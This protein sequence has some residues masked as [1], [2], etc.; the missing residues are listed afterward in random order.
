LEVDV[1]LE[2]EFPSARW[3][4]SL[5]QRMNE[6]R[7]KY[8]RYGF[9]DSVAVFRVT[10]DLALSQNRNFGLKFDGYECVEVRELKDDEIDVFD[11]DWIFE[12]PYDAWKEMIQ[13]IRANGAA[14]SDHTLNRLS[15]LGH[16]FKI[17]GKDQT[18]VDIFFRQ[19]FS[20]QEFIDESAT[21]DTTFA[22]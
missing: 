1:T 16:P 9:M 2:A 19:Q 15:L 18:R 14:D 13:N 7:A 8:E 5:Q 11:P 3:F 17:H 12:A 6:Q 20:F 22:T 21:I 10:G 4:A